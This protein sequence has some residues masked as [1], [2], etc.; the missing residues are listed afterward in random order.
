MSDVAVYRDM[1]DTKRLFVLRCNVRLAYGAKPEFISGDEEE[2][3]EGARGRRRKRGRKAS[4][5]AKREAVW[6][7]VKGNIGRVVVQ[8]SVSEEGTEETEEM[9]EEAEIEEEEADSAEEEEVNF[10]FAFTGLEG[11][12]RG[13]EEDLLSLELSVRA[14]VLAQALH[15]AALL[16]GCQCVLQKTEPTNRLDLRCPCLLALEVEYGEDDEKLF[17]PFF[18]L[19]LLRCDCGEGVALCGSRTMHGRNEET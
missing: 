5:E 14:D 15:I 6:K 18:S 10:P 9:Q 11:K 12:S 1:L 16:E 3:S 4:G 7:V 2:G 17:F 13:T 19:F 8:D